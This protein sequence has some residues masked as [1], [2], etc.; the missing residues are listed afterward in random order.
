MMG[1]PIRPLLIP[2]LLAACG[3]QPPRV[4]PEPGAKPAQAM[5]KPATPRGGGYYLD[6][7][8]G[9]RAP[10]KLD[11]I[12]DALPKA[13]PLHR[14]ANRPYSVFGHDYVP[15]IR[16]SP[17]KA[18]GIASWYGRKYDG[19][20]TAIGET[21][22]MYGMSAA[23]PTLPLPSYVRVT[24]PANGR[25][26]V[27]RV[28]DRGPFHADRLIDLS[29]TAAAKL[30]IVGNG[31][32][33]VEVESVLP[34]EIRPTPAVDPGTLIAQTAPRE[35]PARL[36]ETQD[37]RG[38][39][40]QLGAFSNRDNA[41]NLKSRLGRELEDLSDR[42]VVSALRGIYRVNLGPWVD[43]AEARRVAERLRVAFE[44]NSVVVTR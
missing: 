41:E 1:F 38:F 25:S 9:D 22:D 28:N 13:E 35:E 10:E 31:S 17:Y 16:L 40:L 12:P 44:L 26:V 32:A 5:Q 29:F 11:A 14:F 42:L 7:G 27:V 33:L 20:K 36:P 39:Y 8:P 18:R 23:H 21:Y 19:Q 15:M 3:S 4:V 2:L 30:G 6:D 34:S 37:A 24:N 43:Q